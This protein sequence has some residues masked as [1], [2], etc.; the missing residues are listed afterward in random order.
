M[1]ELQ[2]LTWWYDSPEKEKSAEIGVFTKLP[3]PL[4]SEAVE[5]VHE[6]AI[7]ARRSGLR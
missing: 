5:I 7:R 3:R 4:A 1:C 6:A 2:H